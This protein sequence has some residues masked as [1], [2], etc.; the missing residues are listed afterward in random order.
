MMAALMILFIVCLLVDVI[1][2]VFLTTGAAEKFYVR[3]GVG[4]R[5]GR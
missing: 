3:G 1:N 2:N 4:L 5:A